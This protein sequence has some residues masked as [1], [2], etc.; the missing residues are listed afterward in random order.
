VSRASIATIIPI[1]AYDLLRNEQHVSVL[2]FVVGIIGMTATLCAPVV[3]Q[4]VPR[5][6]VYTTGALLLIAA[7]AS[8]ATHTLPGQA[9][10]MFL[11]TFGGSALA[12]TLNVYIMEFI[13]KHKLVQSE[14]L[15]LA[16]ST[17]AWSAGPAFGVW[18][19]VTFGHAAAYSWSASWALVLIGVFWS[20]RISGN[21]AVRRGKLRPANPIA[22]IRR[23]VAQPRLRLAWMIAFGRSSY[24]MTFYIYAPILMV[25]TGQGKLAGGLIVSCANVLL[26][27][28]IAWG[29]LGSRIGVR[30]VVVLAFAG[31]A[32]AA[33]LAGIAGE[34]HPWIAGLVLLAGVN[35]AV[36]LDAV[37]SAPFLR[38]VHAFERP[39]MTAVYRTNLDMSELLPPFIYSIILAF[40]GLGAVFGALGIFCAVCAIVSWR[41]LPRSM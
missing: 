39:Q 25:A 13:P 29:R 19:Y 11:K 27:F 14:S 34:A 32:A 31:A 6:F 28:A 7:C 4:K 38:A 16:L 10:G 40:G 26:A 12:I 35:F 15:R 23:F 2:Y 21:P 9:T 22:N 20:L 36:A 3:F 41:H 18:L 24:W 30:A 1:Q 33:V 5:R 37:G 17:L 8:F